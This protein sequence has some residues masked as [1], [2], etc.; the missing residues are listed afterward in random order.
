VQGGR[1][2]KATITS[3]QHEITKKWQKMEKE[4]LGGGK[5]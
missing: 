2:K 3:A 5:C 4:V 1:K